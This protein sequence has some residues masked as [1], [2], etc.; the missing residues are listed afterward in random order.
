MPAPA[1]FV[2]DHTTFLGFPLIPGTKC[3]PLI[4][5]STLHS[6]RLSS[7]PPPADVYSRLSI[8]PLSVLLQQ[9]RTILPAAL[10]NLFHRHITTSALQSPISP[11]FPPIIFSIIG[12]VLSSPSPASFIQSIVKLNLF[13]TDPFQDPASV[14]ALLDQIKSSTAWQELAAA[15]TSSQLT[16]P[17]PASSEEPATLPPKTSTSGPSVASLL[18]QLQS[19]EAS[20]HPSSDISDVESRAQFTVEKRANVQPDSA[21][22]KKD[23]RLFSFEESMPVILQLSRDSVFVEEMKK[24]KR[25]QNALERQLWG[26]RRSI[27]KKYEEKLKA[28]KTKAS[29]IGGSISKHDA[30]TLVDAHKKE[31]LKFDRDR[32]LPAWDSLVS[33]QQVKLQRLQVPTMHMTSNS[34][35]RE[36]QQRVIQV[37]TSIIGPSISEK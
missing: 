11:C 4:D 9:V 27:H 33:Q 3:R 23:L 19:P 17:I 7:A 28:A 25:D 35:E 22:P 14:Q 16:E 12:C 6:P 1:T 5:K 21:P 37:L 24:I 13:D 26:E 34:E 10:M 8:T 31:L 2:T 20:S 29:I 30:E 15:S 36:L 32:A 18:S